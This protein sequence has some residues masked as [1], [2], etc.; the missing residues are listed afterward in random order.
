[1]KKIL[2]ILGLVL[3]ML[4]FVACDNDKDMPNV[5]F[6]IEIDDAV[7]VGNTIYV[8]SGDTIDIESITVRNNESDKGAG[9]ASASYYWDHIFIGTNVLAP[10]GMDIAIGETVP[11]GNHE[12][13]IECPVFAQDKSLATAWLGYE[14]KVVESEED[15]PDNGTTTFVVKPSVKEG[16]DK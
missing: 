12:L 15:I 2:L 14:V 7:K 6:S 4:G 1:M 13:V 8:V 11:V 5:T 10:Y 16:S 3:P 9:I